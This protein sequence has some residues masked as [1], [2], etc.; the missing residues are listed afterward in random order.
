MGLR[1]GRRAVAQA[2]LRTRPAGIFAKS[3]GLFYAQCPPGEGRCARTRRTAWVMSAGTVRAS[4]RRCWQPWT[5]L[6]G[7][8]KPALRPLAS[9]M[10]CETDATNSQASRP[11]SS[12]TN[13]SGRWNSGRK[14]A[15][16]KRR[17]A[18]GQSSFRSRLANDTEQMKPGCRSRPRS[19]F[20]IG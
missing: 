3:G 9:R 7:A 13:T 8:S 12:G 20:R 15:G 18:N 17:S 4:W 19:R 6:H 2:R 10:I 5:N 16:I 14:T 1:Y 11:T